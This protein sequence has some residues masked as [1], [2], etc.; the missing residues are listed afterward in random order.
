MGVMDKFLNYMKLNGE[1]DD[2]YYDDDYADEED[3]LDS[4]VSYDRDYRDTIL[5]D[6]LGAHDR[7]KGHERRRIEGGSLRR[8]RLRP[9]R[10]LPPEK[11]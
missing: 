2:D 3:V 8:A 6:V 7:K 11:S 5:F 4:Q 9:S 1:E 10:I